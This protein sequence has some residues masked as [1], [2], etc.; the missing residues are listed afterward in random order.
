LA[1]GRHP[2]THPAR[3]I[4][5]RDGL[6]HVVYAVGENPSWDIQPTWRR[7]EATVSENN[8]KIAVPGF[9]AIYELAGSG[10]A[11]GTFTRGN[12]NSRATMRRVDLAALAEPGF[13]VDW[14]R[15]KSEILQTDLTEDGKPIRLEVVI[16]APPGKVHFRLP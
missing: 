15:G 11:T 7:F 9:S 6:A 16:F 12:M 8:L 14:T 1:L 3:R 4:H 13:V 10:A 5:H 2:K